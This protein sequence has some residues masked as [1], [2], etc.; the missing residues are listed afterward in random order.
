M[1]KDSILKALKFIVVFAINVLFLTYVVETI[2][3]Y[4][5]IPELDSSIIN[6]MVNSGFDS[7]VFMLFLYGCFAAICLLTKSQS[8]VIFLIVCV[9]TVVSIV[10]INN[11]QSLQLE[12]MNSRYEKI[13][14]TGNY[15]KSEHA[16]LLKKAVDAGDTREFVK[17]LT[18]TKDVYETD[19][20]DQ[21]ALLEIIAQITPDLKPKARIFLND[22]YLSMTEYADLKENI[23]KEIQNLNLTGDQISMIR[24]FK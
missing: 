6:P 4:W 18:N 1:M 12:A 2:M 10:S 11:S 14:K 17:L 13:L 19:V 22:D 9:T 7:I 15:A 5:S 23:L 3:T 16:I 21:I 20:N 24:S 8:K